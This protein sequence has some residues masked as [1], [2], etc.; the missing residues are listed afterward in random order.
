MNVLLSSAQ[1]KL[2]GT[3]WMDVDDAKVFKI[4]DLDDIEKTFSAYQRQQVLRAKHFS[5][6]QHTSRIRGRGAGSVAQGSAARIKEAEDDTLSSKKVKE[7]SVIDGRR[8]QNCNI[9][10]SRLKLSN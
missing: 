6:Q 4:L 8:A 9:L 10:L 3:V 1:N 5:P 7:L 2:E